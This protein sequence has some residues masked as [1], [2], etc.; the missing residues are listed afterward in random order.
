MAKRK[1]D[2]VDASASKKP[3]RAGSSNSASSP[4]APAEPVSLQIVT[5]SYERVLHGLIAT[6]EPQPQAQTQTQD[7]PAS[8]VKFADTFLFNAHASAIRCIALSP[9]SE[10]SDPHSQKVILA[11]GST[12]ERINL[13]NLSTAP[14]PKNAQPSIPSLHGTAITQNPKNRELGALTHHSA[15]ITCLK[16]PSRSKLFS[17]ADDNCVSISRTRDW[18]MLSSIKAPI[19]KAQ[20]RPSGD[21]AA[22]G[23]VPSG[24]NDFAVHPSQKLMISVSKGEK[25]MRLWNAMTGKKASVLTFDRDLLQNV[26]EGRWSSGEGRKL[27]WDPEGEE[28]VVA[29]ERGFVTYGLDSR[30]K[31]QTLPRPM[32]KLH[33][34]HYVPN[35]PSSAGPVLA[36]STEDGRILFY[37]SASTVTPAASSDA[38]KKGREV[39]VPSCRLLAQLGGRTAGLTS[40]IK[41]FEI[42]PVAEGADRYFIITGC[43]DG[44]V[45][46]WRLNGEDLLSEIEEK[47][48]ASDA[49][50]EKGP[51]VSNTLGAKQV[52]ELLGAHEGGNRITC[53]KAFVM[54]GAP[55]EADASKE[56]E[57]EASSSD[58]SDSE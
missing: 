25:C 4:D 18:T 33:Q 5:G 47:D 43:S 50:K 36:V 7:K 10:G 16:F 45:R 23:E 53:L 14:P 3:H 38:V 19:P 34:L 29:F 31:A 9:P 28:W 6:V 20:G 26:G 40:R 35:L 52:G 41:D 44:A 56:E 21:T 1:L 2:A 32:T 17:G 27:E 15:T 54:T 13:Y 55:E 12:D 57:D 37:S 58:D 48:E 42:L 8:S 49:V 46:V 24:I 22:P 11:S 30:P 51:N 39:S